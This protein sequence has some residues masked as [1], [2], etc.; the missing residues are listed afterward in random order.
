MARSPWPLRAGAAVLFVLLAL[1]ARAA[2][3]EDDD[4]RKAILELC[5][6]APR[7]DAT[8]VDAFVDLMV[9]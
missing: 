5:L 7:L 4:A 1:P 9:A 8:P 2:L 3:F 6:D